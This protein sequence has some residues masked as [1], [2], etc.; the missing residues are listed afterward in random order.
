MQT[1]F[2]ALEHV[3]DVIGHVAGVHLPELPALTTL[4]VW[5]ANSSYRLVATGGSNVYVQGGTCFTDPT[6]ACVDGA[7][8]GSSLLRVGWI[9]VGFGMEIRARGRVISTSP[10]R[11]IA[12]EAPGIPTVH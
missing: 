8:I 10:V 7:R 12:T 2:V 5:T 11:A 9:G 6:A 1:T 4:L 3:I